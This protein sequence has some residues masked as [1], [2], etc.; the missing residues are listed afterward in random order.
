M[1]KAVLVIGARGFLGSQVVSA[2][3]SKKKYSV[4]A[5]IRPGSDA[6]K[7]ENI[8]IL[9]G[10]MMDPD[11]LV[12]AFENVD[13]VINT[14]NGYSQGHPEIDVEGAKNVADAVKKKGVDRL[15][16][17]GVLKA[18]KAVGVE[19]FEDKVKVE[20]YM[21]EI[22]ISYISLHPG[23]FLDQADDYLGSAIQKGSSFTLC[24]FNKTT[25]IGS[26]YTADLAKYFAEAVDLPKEAD[27][28]HIDVGWSRSTSF[29]EVV[30][31]AS[32]DK[33]T[34]V[35][36][37]WLVRMGLIYTVGWFSP[38][39]TEMIRMFIFFDTGL[40]VNDTTLQTKYFGPPPTP[41]DAIGRYVA[42]LKKE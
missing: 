5:L 7:L 8:E 39:A 13:V 38:L 10:D 26:I 33:I 42:N 35:G 4:K 40:Y 30:K 27:G 41:E 31:I 18:E 11:S 34:C 29:Q 23:A 2:L 1:G 3:L 14:A 9:R 20:N 6:S 19:H 36:L 32:D 37:P 16:Y 12:K 28:K 17:C 15:I 24:P 21:K 25:K 22:G